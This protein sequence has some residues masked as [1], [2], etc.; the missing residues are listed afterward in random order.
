MIGLLLVFSGRRRSRGRSQPRPTYPAI[1]AFETA[2]AVAKKDMSLMFSRYCQCSIQ[3]VASVKKHFDP[4][5]CHASACPV[6]C[7]WVKRYL[8]AALFIAH[9]VCSFWITFFFSTLCWLRLLY[10]S[11]FPVLLDI[12]TFVI[13]LF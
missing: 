1:A 6:W 3:L 13:S 10:M 7:T 9:H 5:Y 2:A 4:R 12:S 8:S 11:Y